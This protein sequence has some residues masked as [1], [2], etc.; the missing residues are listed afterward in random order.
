MTLFLAL[1]KGLYL[2]ELLEDK[3][4]HSAPNKNDTNFVKSNSLF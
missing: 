2:V 1:Q 3:V 4:Y